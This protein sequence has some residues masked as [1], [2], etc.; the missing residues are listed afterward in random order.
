MK[1][2]SSTINKNETEKIKCKMK[3][4]ISH[5][6]TRV[7]YLVL[8]NKLFYQNKFVIEKHIKFVIE[9]DIHIK[10]IEQ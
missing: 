8:F 10:F 9:T 2:N 7:I 4:K 3:I 1:K 5:I 6:T